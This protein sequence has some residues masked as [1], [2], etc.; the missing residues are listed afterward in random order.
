M[1]FD[2]ITQTA[3][4]L[5]QKRG[6]RKMG[7]KAW[8]L[9]GLPAASYAIGCNRPPTKRGLKREKLRSLPDDRCVATASPVKRGL[10]QSELLGLEGPAQELKPPP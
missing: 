3:Q 8:P 1:N 10:K 2:E 5:T 7:S 6:L 9:S 4:G